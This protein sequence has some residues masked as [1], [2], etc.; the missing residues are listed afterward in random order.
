M[1]SY[2]LEKWIIQ[3]NQWAEKDTKIHRDKK[4]AIEIPAKTFDK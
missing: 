1:W 4:I 2:P 3:E